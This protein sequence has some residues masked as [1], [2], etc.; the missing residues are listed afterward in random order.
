MLL[1][2]PHNFMLQGARQLVDI[3]ARYNRLLLPDHVVARKGLQPRLA[4][5]DLRANAVA[6]HPQ[7]RSQCAATLLRLCMLMCCPQLLI[8]ALE[9]CCPYM[10]AHS[11]TCSML[12]ASS[13]SPA[14]QVPAPAAPAR[15]GRL[16]W[17]A[18]HIG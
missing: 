3:D 10:R 1:P 7:Y 4:R 12:R 8:H 16:G 5:M 13:A 14:E 6:A 11:T 18:G 9:H 17:L 15:P 2:S